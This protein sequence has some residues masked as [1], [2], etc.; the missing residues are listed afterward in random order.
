MSASLLHAIARA[1]LV[2]VGRVGAR[3]GASAVKSVLKDAD[4]A[5]A[6]ARRRFARAI[7]RLDGL[8]EPRTPRDEEGR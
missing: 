8:G 6:E 5:A 7:E 4:G 3:A 2:E 1:A